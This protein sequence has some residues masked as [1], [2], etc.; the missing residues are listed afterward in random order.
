MEI[1][2]SKFPIEVTH[3]DLDSIR[4]AVQAWGKPQDV[5]DAF[6]GARLHDHFERCALVV[7]TDSPDW[8]ISEYD[9]DLGCRVWIQVA[10][11]HSS[12]KTRSLLEDV[13]RPLDDAFKRKMR[14]SWRRHRT[15]EA[16]LSEGPYFWETHTIH[17]EE[18]AER[19]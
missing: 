1:R 11:E 14:P 3:E 8:D 10:I 7:D 13:V 17:P 19:A 18:F 6:N 9:H 4:A 2:Q 12:P 16:P 15:P 5:V